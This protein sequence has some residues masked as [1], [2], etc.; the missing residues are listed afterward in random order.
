LD[1][2][3]G[4]S[5]YFIGSDPRLWRSNVP[6]YAR[7][8]YRDIYPGIDLLFYGTPQGDLECDFVVSPGANANLVRLDFAGAEE[9]ALDGEGNLLFEIGVG[10]LRLRAPVIYQQ[11]GST[12]HKLE[13]GYAIEPQGQVRFEIAAYDPK[14][15]LIIDPILYS[16]Y[17]G[18][19]GEDSGGDV[20]VDASGAAYIVGS[21]RS[22]N[23]PTTPGVA[24]PL[25]GSTCDSPACTDAFIAKINPAGTA[26]VYSTFLGGS[27]F[28]SG[29][30]VDVDGL[31]NAFVAGDTLSSNFPTTTGAFQTAL[32]GARDGF[33]A[34]LNANGSALGYSTYLGGSGDEVVNAV[35]IDAGGHAYSAGST[36]STNFPTKIPVRASL[37]GSED[38]FLTKLN[39]AG[40]ALVYSTYWGGNESCCE[41]IAGLAV[42]GSGSA[43]VVGSTNAPDFPTTPG[44]LRTALVGFS[45]AFV[46]K[47]GTGGDTI[48]YSTLL[49]GSSAS[50]G[51]GAS[52]VA[53]DADGNA[54]VAGGTGATDFP[55][56]VGA[57]QP[58]FAGGN[59]DAF[60][61]KLNPLGNGL[62]FA[63]YLGGAGDEGAGA[64]ALDSARRVYVGGGTDS[65]AFPTVNPIQPTFGGGLSDGFVAV[66]SAS[67]NSLLF[68]TYLGGSGFIR[69]SAAGIAV[70]PFGNVLVTGLT[71][72]DDFPIA[73]ALQGSRPGAFDAFVTKIEVGLPSAGKHRV[74][75]VSE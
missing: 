73:N 45:D 58:A 12:R 16:T 6:N 69:E 41:N 43:Y 4:R 33:V 60:V 25:P 36:T 38:G 13:G 70:D 63:T 53:V 65:L 72:S 28:D 31:G 17:L 75:V 14:H 3:P 39:P 64:I 19:S 27:N 49:G 40:S 20:A 46:S 9:P 68:S 21:T 67:G 26:L 15:A 5:N 56:T 2:L 35:A 62:L 61:A 37:S 47:L 71:A 24:Q 23:F 44:A 42:D 48:V 29:N 1:E 51:D 22:A 8:R 18:G 66:L 7:V 57:Y 54:Y 52:A 50:N 32:S 11:V 34:M 10:D 74:Q 59:A 30:A 55:A